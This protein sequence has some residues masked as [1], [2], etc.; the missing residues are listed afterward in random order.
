M[1]AYGMHINISA[2]VYGLLVPFLLHIGIVT[3]QIGTIRYVADIAVCS[4]NENILDNA[5]KHIRALQKGA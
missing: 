5:V 2:H 1:K 4:D 3:D